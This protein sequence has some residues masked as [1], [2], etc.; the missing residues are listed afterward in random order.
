M[1]TAKPEINKLNIAFLGSSIALLLWAG[2]VLTTIV[3]GVQD[4][5]H[6]FRSLAEDLALLI[7]FSSWLVAILCIV[8]ILIF[9][10]ALTKGLRFRL[11][12]LML[13]I[14]PIVIASF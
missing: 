1:I 10:R 13:A 11:S 7:A 2:I 3:F 8:L 14:P 4:T 12:C 9:N 6:G 5:H